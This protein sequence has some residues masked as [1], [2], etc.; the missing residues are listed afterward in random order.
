MT[1]GMFG[2][3][4][5]RASQKSE[6]FHDLFDSLNKFDVPI[7]G[8]HTETG[9]GVYEAAIQY[10]EILEAADLLVLFKSGAKEIAQRHGLIASFMAKWNE[11]LPGCSGHVHQSLWSLDKKHNLFYD[12]KGSKGM[13]SLLESY[14]AGQLSVCP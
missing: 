5:L 12:K 4:I 3:S 6:F 2:Y 11:N 10:S 7:E 8:I 9:P 14:I 13:S 1:P